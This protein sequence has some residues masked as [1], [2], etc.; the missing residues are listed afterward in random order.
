MTREIKFPM[1]MPERVVCP[2]GRALCA[3]LGL[4][5]ETCR[6]RSDHRPARREAVR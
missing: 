4:H 3:W 6:G 2:L 5:N 1:W